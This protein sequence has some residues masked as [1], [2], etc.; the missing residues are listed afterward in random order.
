MKQNIDLPDNYEAAWAEL[1]S[2]VQEL[3]SDNI[4]VDLLADKVARAAALAEFCRQRL[5][6]AESQLENLSKKVLPEQ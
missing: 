1:Q 6:Q 3:Q 2:I 4:Q 5:R